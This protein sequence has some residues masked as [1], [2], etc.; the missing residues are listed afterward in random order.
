MSSDDTERLSEFLSKNGLTH[1]KWLKHFKDKN[2]TK[3]D[4]IH[5]LEYKDDV[6]TALLLDANQGEMIALQ[7][8]FEIEAPIDAPDVGLDRELNE[9][10]LDNPYWS[11]VSKGNLVLN[12]NKL[13]KTLGRNR[14]NF[15]PSL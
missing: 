1:N 14:S 9:V 12:L 10:G 5:E 6:F 3:V 13:S 2:I 11:E 4:E 15:W 7:K 8:I